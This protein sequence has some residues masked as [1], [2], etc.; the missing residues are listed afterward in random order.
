[1]AASA[2]PS[3]VFAFLVGLPLLYWPQGIESAP[4][5]K[6]A[7]IERLCV[8]PDQVDAWQKAG[9]TPVAM[10]QADLESRVKLMEPRIAGRVAVASPT[11]SPWVDANGWRIQRNSAGKYLYDLPKGRAALAAAEAFAYGADAVLK[12]DP[13]D[14]EELGQMFAF[15]RELPQE[16]LP[17]V[18]DFAVVDDGSELTGEVMNL[19]ARRNLLFRVLTASSPQFPINVRLGTAEYPTAQAANPSEFALK[20]RR[21]LTDEKRSLRLY[22][23]EVVI[24]RLNSDGSRARVHM[25][26]YSGRE[27][28]GLRLRV[29]GMYS[30]GQAVAAGIGRLVLDDYVAVDGATEFSI[31]RLGLYAVVDL[32]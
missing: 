32:N 7:G 8:P 28:G 29:R 23:S 9:F 3:F 2:L 16:S 26:N 19:L 27:I 15:L 18:A 13:A 10:S 6:Q 30:K 24:C 4:A 17:P 31:P 14:L 21:Q 11:R 25:L 5:L 1:M 22:G 20:I 12:I